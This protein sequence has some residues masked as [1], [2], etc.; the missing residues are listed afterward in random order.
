MLVGCENHCR[1]CQGRGRRFEPGLP[2]HLILEIAM[3]CVGIG[4]QMVALVRL[5]VSVVEPM[6]SAMTLGAPILIGTLAMDEHLPA[7]DLLAVFGVLAFVL[8]VFGSVVPARH[9]ESEVE[10]EAAAA[11]GLQGSAAWSRC[12][13]A[14]PPRAAR[15]S[16]M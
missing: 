9:A 5:S 16:R 14:R 15:C 1:P 10:P 3:E 11:G 8:T 7:N 13:V 12:P 4:F 2:L 6:Y